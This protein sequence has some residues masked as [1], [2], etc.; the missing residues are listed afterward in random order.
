M[1]IKKMFDA[2]LFDMDG[3]LTNTEPLWEQTTTKVV[4]QFDY[5]WTEQDHKNTIGYSFENLS[6]YVWEKCGHANNPEWFLNQLLD[7]LVASFDG[8]VPLMPGAEDLL[9]QVQQS[10]IPFG[11]V[12][13]NTR[14]ICDLVIGTF[15]DIKFPVTITVNDV[16]NPKPDPEGYLKAAK[17]LGVQNK[18]V[19]IFE[20]S[21]PGVRAAAASGAR[22]C[23]VPTYPG[24]MP[25]DRIRIVNSLTEVNLDVISDWFANW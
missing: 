11:L 6:N 1:Q 10:G 3:L 25:T 14:K 12:T 9:T 21:G 24:I 7:T 23:A 5:T 13:S 4:S 20:D 17:L 19:L 15:P 18:D 8:E 22:V 2:I 16:S